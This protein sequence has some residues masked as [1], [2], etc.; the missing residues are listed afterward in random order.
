[1]Y[2]DHSALKYLVNKQVL[3][4]NICRWLLMFQEYDFEFVVKPGRLNNGL[5]HLSRIESGEDPTSLDEGLPDAQLF[6]ISIVDDYFSDIVEFL[7]SRMA[8]THY[9]VSHKKQLV[10]KASDY[11]LIAGHL[12]K[13]IPDEILCRCVLDHEKDSILEEAHG[14]IAGGHYAGKAMAHKI[15]RVGL[16]WPTL[17]KDAKGYCQACDVFQRMGNPSTRDDMPLVP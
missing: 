14:G 9:T 16:W 1:M 5:D 4:G 2:T 3:G 8:P 11:Q 12:Y 7:S 10:V 13:R 15:L 6:S 17:H